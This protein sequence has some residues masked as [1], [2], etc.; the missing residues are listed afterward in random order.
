M[1]KR[2]SASGVLIVVELG[3]DWPSFTQAL[4]PAVA[5]G[6]RVLAQEEGESPALFGSRVA[7]QLDTLF[8]RGVPLATAV[9]ACNERLDDAARGARA[10]LARSVMGV[11]ARERAGALLLSASDTNS[12]RLRQALSSL[13]AEL[14]AEWQRAGVRASVR[15]EPSGSAAAGPRSERS[16]ANAPLSSDRPSAKPSARQVA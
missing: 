2:K 16:R 9:I 13:A 4:K 3:A 14:G 15:D 11:M 7:E 5:A 10:E 12:D 1:Q 6:R 8:A